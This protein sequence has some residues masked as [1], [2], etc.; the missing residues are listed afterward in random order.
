MAPTSSSTTYAERPDRQNVLELLSQVG[1]SD[2]W[3]GRHPIGTLI[4]TY[5][6]KSR[7]LFLR[8][9]LKRKP[10]IVIVAPDG[11]SASNY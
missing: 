8:W 4:V 2:L 10:N 7:A 11:Q 9:Y 3:M 1:E 5:L 6:L